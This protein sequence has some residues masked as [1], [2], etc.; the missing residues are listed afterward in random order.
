[1]SYPTAS[2][3]LIAALCTRAPSRW[4]KS[5]FSGVKDEIQI[6]SGEDDGIQ[7][8]ARDQCVSEGA[9]V[10]YHK[11]LVEAHLACG[12]RPRL[13][14]VHA[15]V[16]HVMA[17]AQAR[18]SRLLAEYLA[19]LL[20]QLARGGAEIAT[21]PAFAPQV[22][23]AELAGLTPI[24]LISLLEAISS[25]VKRRR[26]RRIALFGA[27]VTMETQMF[28]ALANS[29]DIYVRVVETGR[30]SSL[31]PFESALHPGAR[32]RIRFHFLP[33]KKE[34]CLSLPATFLACAR[35]TWQTAND[36]RPER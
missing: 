26:L 20:G 23:A 13:L 33:T 2:S 7:F 35:Q 14:M 27:R 8:F 34:F 36:R 18:E 11:S 30:A 29:A 21:I 28:G 3:S 22:C 17:L 19:G 15:D 10:F 16:R 6:G 1:M 31:A 12:L 9:G 24:P 32:N 25:A 5:V 4:G